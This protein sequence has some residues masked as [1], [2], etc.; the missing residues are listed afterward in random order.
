MSE[1]IP[2]EKLKISESGIHTRADIIALE[3]AGYNAVLIGE[4]LMRQSDRTAFL[5]QLRGE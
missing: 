1:F 4:T 5:K 2:N 3:K